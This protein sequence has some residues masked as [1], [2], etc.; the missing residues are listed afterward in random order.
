[1]RLPGEGTLEVGLCVRGS[2]SDPGD[3][4]GGVQTDT[5]GTVVERSQEALARFARLDPKRR[6]S[7]R[8]VLSNI[9]IAVLQRGKEG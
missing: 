8:G 1:M 2:D 6:E 3:R 4:V 5:H 9:A 7:A